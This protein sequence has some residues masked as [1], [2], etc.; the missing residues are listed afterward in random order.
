MK[1]E[2]VMVTSWNWIYLTDFSEYKPVHLPQNNPSDFSF[3]F[4]TSSR[5]NCYVAPERFQTGELNAQ[6]NITYQMDIFSVG[7][8]IAEL[9]LDGSSLF[10][11][12]QLLKYKTGAY[13]PN[14]EIDKI[15]DFEIQS[16]VRHMIQL[17]PLKRLQA[18]EYLE[19]WRSKAFPDC[20]YT[21]LH[22]YIAEVNE[23]GS[24]SF[25]PADTHRH[26]MI[27]FGADYKI[28]KIFDDFNRIIVSL[29]LQHVF[30]QDADSE[31]N[32]IVDLLPVSLGIPN[33]KRNTLKINKSDNESRKGLQ[34]ILSLV[35]S[36]VRNVSFP[37]SK[38]KAIDLILAISTQLQDDEILDRIVPYLINLVN[39][40]NRGVC[41]HAIKVLTQI[42]SL[43]KNITLYD[44]FV[45]SEY[46]IPALKIHLNDSDLF[47][48]VNL[49]YCIPLIGI[50]N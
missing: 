47:L 37:S 4:D 11:L 29:E 16:L 46:I 50:H 13:D 15:P 7:C 27:K 41:V 34:V 9:F 43:I 44:T 17:D 23:T 42:M 48:R 3:F 2:N 33:I 36:S 49:A 26:Q 10:N 35:L 8:T 31:P 18:S 45:F 21:F 6:A 25:V 38:I 20:F 1:T 24:Q 22:Q 14:P 5:R 28:I 32:E 12:S 39:D 40:T 30:Y 19:K